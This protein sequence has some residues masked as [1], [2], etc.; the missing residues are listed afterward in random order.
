MSKWTGNLLPW[1][2]DDGAVRMLTKSFRV[3]DWVEVNGERR[4]VMRVSSEPAPADDP[5]IGV[6]MGEPLMTVELSP[7]DVE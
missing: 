6:L 1:P 7:P 2:Y 5:E 3:G 4:R